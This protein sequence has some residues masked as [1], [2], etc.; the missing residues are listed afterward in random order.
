[1]QLL[2]I[3]TE[4]QKVQRFIRCF[5]TNCFCCKYTAFIQRKLEIV[6]EIHFTPVRYYNLCVTTTVHSLYFHNSCFNAILI[7]GGIKMCKR[8]NT[9]ACAPTDVVLSLEK[10]TSKTQSLFLCESPTETL[11]VLFVEVCLVRNG[12]IETAESNS[13]ILQK[14]FLKEQTALPCVCCIPSRVTRVRALR[15]VMRYKND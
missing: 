15:E 13:I 8:P 4:A 6:R 1:M 14:A 5:H 9:V 10:L 3:S 2:R 12:K 11:Q 7:R